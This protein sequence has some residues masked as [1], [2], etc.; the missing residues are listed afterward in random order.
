MALKI[1]RRG[2]D[3]A[4]TASQK[5]LR[6]GDDGTEQNTAISSNDS[7]RIDDIFKAEFATKTYNRALAMTGME[8]TRRKYEAYVDVITDNIL[9]FLGL[10]G[11][12]EREDKGRVRAAI[13]RAHERELFQ[14]VQDT[15]YEGLGITYKKVV[16]ITSSVNTN[17]FNCYTGSVLVAD[18]LTRMGKRVGLAVRM[19]HIQVVG[20]SLTLDTTSAS[21]SN[22]YPKTKL[23]S[24]R[25]SPYSIIG[26]GD[27]LLAEAY[28]ISANNMIINN[29]IDKAVEFCNRAI[30][31][32][33][34][35]YRARYVLGN[36]LYSRGEYDKAMEAYG[37]ALRAYPYDNG[38]INGMLRATNK[39]GDRTAALSDL[40]R[41][42]RDIPESPFLHSE[43]GYFL[44]SIGRSHM[45]I[46]EYDEAI[47]SD[48][49]YYRPWNLKAYLLS[50]L[51]EDKRAIKTLLNSMKYVGGS[52]NE[53]ALS[54]IRLIEARRRS[55]STESVL[56]TPE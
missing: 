26:V 9:G 21:H 14:F 15:L 54:L 51:G 42:T 11:D 6:S 1:F 40:Q 35:C 5:L 50:S 20:D 16:T 12:H 55:G 24:M 44:E 47:R 32:N 28:S 38:L 56:P 18:V 13:N 22:I 34:S 37:N 2:S 23:T 8:L 48:R 7:V 53:I 4:L 3:G 49:S 27:D 29:R 45:A 19:S 39:I 43:V 41:I 46:S 31:L 52:H 10:S 17:M 36:I 30:R 33:P 25:Y